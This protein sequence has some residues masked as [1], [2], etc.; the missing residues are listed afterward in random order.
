MSKNVKTS[1]TR[2]ELYNQT[3]KFFDMTEEEYSFLFFDLG[4]K[5]LKTYYPQ[6]IELLKTRAYWRLFEDKM[7]QRI[8]YRYKQD[9]SQGLC[10]I[11]SKENYEMFE[12]W[13]FQHANWNSELINKVKLAVEAPKATTRPR[14]PKS[15]NNQ[16]ETNLNTI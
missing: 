4:T 9:I 16:L 13:V 6:D 8:D 1:T 3:L 5:Y 14:T 2:E 15:K 7:M 10:L 12:S 11:K